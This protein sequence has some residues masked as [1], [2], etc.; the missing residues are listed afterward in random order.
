MSGHRSSRHE[1]ICLVGDF[2]SVR[3]RNSSFNS[4]EPAV[5]V[6][7]FLASPPRGTGHRVMPGQRLCRD[8]MPRPCLACAGLGWAGLG[9]TRH[10]TDTERRGGMEVVGAGVAK[11]G[12]GTSCVKM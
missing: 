11:N 3:A 12:I 7:C 10:G 4:G 1:I 8:L 2:K 9:W 6:V 5:C